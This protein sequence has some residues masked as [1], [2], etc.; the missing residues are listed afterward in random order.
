MLQEKRKAGK[1]RKLAQ[2]S[3]Y[4]PAFP[5]LVKTVKRLQ[6]EDIGGL[7]LMSSRCCR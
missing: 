3:R 6:L 5:A 2:E 4:F 7:V 1:D